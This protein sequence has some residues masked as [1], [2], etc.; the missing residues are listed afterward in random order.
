MIDTGKIAEVLRSCELI[1]NIE[2]YPTTANACRKSI[3]ELEKPAEDDAKR[4][5]VLAWRSNEHPGGFDWIDSAAIVIQQYAE[6]YHAK[7]CAECKDRDCEKCAHWNNGRGLD[8][9]CTH[10]S[11][12]SKWQP[13][14]EAPNA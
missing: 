6:S 11:K 10:C 5:A 3:A 13:V 8:V 4:T 7:K 14:S 1:A 12:G 2:G 9:F